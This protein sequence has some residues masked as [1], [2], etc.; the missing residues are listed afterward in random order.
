MATTRSNAQAS[1]CAVLGAIAVTAGGLSAGNAFNVA[2]SRQPAASSAGAS[3]IASSAAEKSAKTFL[4]KSEAST[5]SNQISTVAPLLALAA[6]GALARGRKQQKASHITLAAAAGPD[7]SGELGVTPPLG[8]W[9]PLGLSVNADPNKAELNFRRRRL[10]EIQHGRLAMLATLGY[11]VPEFFRFPGYLSPSK[12]IAFADLPSGLAAASKVPLTGWAQIIAFA[13][14][15]EIYNLQS[16]PTG[17]AGDFEQYG[18]FGIPFG[19]NSPKI[20]DPEKK[21][22]SLNAEINNGRLAMM[23]IIGMFFQDGLTGQAWG[24]WANYTDSPLRQ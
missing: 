21:M 2:G 1:K 10:V 9:D 8:Y 5:S 11:I 19:K 13:G 23:A 17:I 20:T 16:T 24:D 15:V 7:F 3:A 22:K 6:G 18:Q 12:G 4:M 14:V